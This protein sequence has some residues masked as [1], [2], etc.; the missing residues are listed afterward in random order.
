MQTPENNELLFN[1]MHNANGVK[2]F[3]S[4]AEY[5]RY[6][7]NDHRIYIRFV[8]RALS[9][10]SF[11]LLGIQ[12]IIA[13]HKGQEKEIEHEF[14]QYFTRFPERFR[15]STF[16]YLYSIVEDQY[17]SL[18]RKLKESYDLNFDLEDIKGNGIQ[19][20]KTYISKALQ[21]DIWVDSEWEQL[22]EYQKIRNGLVHNRGI[23]SEYRKLRQTFDITWSEDGL[24]RLGPEFLRGFV[25]FLLE[26]LPKLITRVTEHKP[27]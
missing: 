11:D 6:L 24:A 1:E 8:E 14:F 20:A 17:N 27:I 19:R 16:V 15:N 26:H 5:V 2:G 18:S 3:Q 21:V 23:I 9:K 13:T 7:L 25:S 22:K 12:R 4:D 10:K